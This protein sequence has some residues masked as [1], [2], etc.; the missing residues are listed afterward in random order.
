MEAAAAAQIALALPPPVRRL[1]P[2]PHPNYA[3]LGRCPLFGMPQRPALPSG[4]DDVMKVVGAQ[5]LAS[6]RIE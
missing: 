5:G 1:L 3:A 2:R 6:D 4:M